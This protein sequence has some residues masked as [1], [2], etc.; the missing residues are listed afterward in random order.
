[1]ALIYYE[2][3]TFDINA[4]ILT[5]ISA[6]TYYLIGNFLINKINDNYFRNAITFI[7]LIYGFVSI[8]SST[9]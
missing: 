8:L 2:R 1:M 4:L 6:S 3:F 5:F 9:S 7:I